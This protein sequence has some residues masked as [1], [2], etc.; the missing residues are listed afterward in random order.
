MT[1]A[2]WSVKENRQEYYR[3]RLKDKMAKD[4]AERKQ[5]DGQRIRAPRLGT[6][7]FCSSSGTMRVGDKWH[8]LSHVGNYS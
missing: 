4:Y 7:A 1:R 6:F 3:T 2:Q 8:L 5:E